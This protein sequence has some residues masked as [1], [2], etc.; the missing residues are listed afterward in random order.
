MTSEAIIIRNFDL[1][2]KIFDNIDILTTYYKLSQRD[3]NTISILLSYHNS[4]NAYIEMKMKNFNLSRR[5]IYRSLDKLKEKN[6]IHIVSRPRN[7]YQ[8]LKL[9][10]TIDFVM[11]IGGEEFGSLYKKWLEWQMSY[12]EEKGEDNGTVT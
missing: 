12:K 10:F 4:Y 3:I 9:Y 6:I 1:T 7:Q 11:N 5:L 8:L 2:K